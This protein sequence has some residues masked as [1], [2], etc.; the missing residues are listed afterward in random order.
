MLLF[1]QFGRCFRVDLARSEIGKSRGLAFAEFEK[2]DSAR[3][4]VE[5]LDGAQIDNQHLR[6]ELSQY[7]PDDLVKM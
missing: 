2:T 3:L 1:R 7:P 5:Y 4:A 6:V